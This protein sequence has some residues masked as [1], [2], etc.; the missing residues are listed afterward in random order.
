V[1]EYQTLL[2]PHISRWSLAVGT[3]TDPVDLEIRYKWRIGKSECFSW[4]SG[5]ISSQ[6]L[7]FWYFDQIFTLAIL[8][9]LA[10][11]PE[12]CSAWPLSVQKPWDI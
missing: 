11:H 10:S 3:S 4:K 9:G 8:N 6:G 7:R 1:I 12:W 5:A 2:Q